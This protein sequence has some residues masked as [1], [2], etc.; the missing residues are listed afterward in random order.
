M[1]NDLTSYSLKDFRSDIRS[2][3]LAVA[4]VRPRVQPEVVLELFHLL[5]RLAAGVDSLG[6]MG[7]DLGAELTRIETIHNTL[8][9]NDRLAV[10]TLNKQGGLEKLRMQVQGADG[11]WWWYLDLHVAE[12][13]IQQTKRTLRNVSLG[14]LVLAVLVVAY[15]IFLR[16]DEATRLRY[17]YTVDAEG[18]IE[19]G[20]Y[21]AALGFYQK[22]LE[23]APDDPEIHLM[24]GM[25]YEA[26]DRPEDAADHYAEAEALYENPVLFMTMKSQRYIMLGWHQESET[27]ALAAIELDDQ[28]ALAYCNLGGAYE[29][30]GRVGEAIGAF[31]EF[32][33]DLG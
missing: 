25:M 17:G 33:I 9:D 26:L 8:L 16:P 10:R 23:V 29:G 11:R 32:L 31:F 22:A 15:V 4:R 21:E 24:I 20:N 1:S 30:Q 7:V 2:A 3:E 27:T 14:A 12:S 13:R 19:R 6:N 5:D 28:F 18:Q